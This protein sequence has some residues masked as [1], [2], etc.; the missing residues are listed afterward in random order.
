MG[1][2]QF[3]KR[4]IIDSARYSQDRYSCES[5]Y[6]RVAKT[7]SINDVIHKR[8][9]PYVNAAGAMAHARAN[10][11][12]PIKEPANWSDMGNEWEKARPALSKFLTLDLSSL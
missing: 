2:K 4:E 5:V 1:R 8:F 7:P 6:S 11:C 12:K 10:F 3:S 9:F